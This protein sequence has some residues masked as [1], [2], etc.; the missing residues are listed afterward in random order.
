MSTTKLTHNKATALTQVQALI[1]GTEKHFPN[2][3]LTFGNATH[4]AAELTQAL[5]SLANALAA[6]AVAHVRIKDAGTALSGVEATVGP[7]VRDYKS[8]IHATFATAAQTLADFGLKARKAPT[9]LTSDKRA[10]ATAKLRATRDARG[11][12]SKK[13]KLAVKGNVTS[14]QITPVTVTPVTSQSAAPAEPT[15]PL[16]PGPASTVHAASVTAK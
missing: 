16:T 7:L 4:T 5:E 11:T 14:V 13:Q 10:V 6:L 12:T 3:S 2:G 8:F 9:P 1:A 15:A